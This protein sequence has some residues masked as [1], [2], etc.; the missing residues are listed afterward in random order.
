MGREDLVNLKHPFFKDLKEGDEVEVVIRHKVESLKELRGIADSRII[1]S[2]NGEMRDWMEQSE[3][4]APR[5]PVPSID[6]FYPRR[7]SAIAR[8]SSRRIQPR[9]AQYLCPSMLS[10]NTNKRNCSIPIFRNCFFV[11]SNRHVPIPIFL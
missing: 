11:L 6:L 7:S 9:P 5:I 1:F 10:A 2:P 3:E 8:I 4:R